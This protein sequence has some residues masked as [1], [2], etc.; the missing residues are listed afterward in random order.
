MGSKVDKLIAEGLQFHR[1]GLMDDGEVAGNFI[2]FIARHGEQKNFDALPL[3]AKKEVRK[4]IEE[5]K[6]TRSWKIFSS[7]GVRDMSEVVDLF[8]RRINI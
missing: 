7:E 3:W 5:Y 4:Q 8:I 2:F 1:E 6:L